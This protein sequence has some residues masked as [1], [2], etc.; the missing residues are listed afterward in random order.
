[1]G[2]Q[3]KA[4]VDEDSRQFFGVEAGAQTHIALAAARGIEHKVVTATVGR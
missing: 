1:M 4:C 2:V 3:H